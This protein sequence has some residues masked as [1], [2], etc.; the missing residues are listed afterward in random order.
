MV[1]SN[2]QELI[3]ELDATQ[4]RYVRKK[5]A[6]GG[7]EAWK[8]SVVQHWLNEREANRQAAERRSKALWTKAMVAATALPLLGAVIQFLLNRL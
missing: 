8:S 4:E 5:L 6:L 1:P 7:Y 2:A 3:E